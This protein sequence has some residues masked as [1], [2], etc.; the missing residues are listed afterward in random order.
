[1][2]IYSRASLFWLRSVWSG[3]VDLV[4]VVKKCWHQV[5]IISKPP[6]RRT[7]NL[8]GIATTRLALTMLYNNQ[9]LTGLLSRRLFNASWWKP[10]YLTLAM[11]AGSER[12]P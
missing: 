5:N 8:V 12:L 7:S 11:A 2:G 10:F 6:H 3:S 1:M 4:Q 9:L